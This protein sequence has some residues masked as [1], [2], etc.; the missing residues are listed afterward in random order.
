MDDFKLLSCI[1]NKQL[2][3]KIYSKLNEMKEKNLKIST[4]QDLLLKSIQNVNHVLVDYLEHENNTNER[5]KEAFSMI[6]T[7][8]TRIVNIKE[9]INLSKKLLNELRNK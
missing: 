7:M 8:Y 3:T 5:Q 1:E 9:E 2:T 6:N 4:T